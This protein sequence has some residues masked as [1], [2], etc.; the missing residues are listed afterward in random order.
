MLK[1]SQ[2]VGNLPL[3]IIVKGIGGFYYVKTPDGLYECK[4]RGIFR[5]NNSI[6]LPGDK[7]EVSVID[8]KKKLGSLDRILERSSELVRPAVANVNQVAIVISVKSPSPDF[9]LLDKLIISAEQKNLNIAICINKIDLDLNKEHEKIVKMYENTHYKIILLSTVLGIGFEDLKDTLAGKMTVFSGQSGVGKSTILNRVVNSWAMKTGNISEKIER[10][11][12]T[13]RHAEIFELEYGGYIVD[14]PGFSS[15][16][17]SDIK[18][19]ELELYF[20]EFEDHLNKCKFTH[21][22]H[23]NEPFC[24]IKEAVSSGLVNSERYKRYTELFLL[25]KQNKDYKN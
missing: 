4:A 21:C 15:F 13:T 8:D 2:E 18:Y 12:H 6:P 10:G 19:N 22:S 9:V 16:E 14:T 1:N 24:S 20:P 5:K 25:L 3:G 11:K 7:V 23:I 17:L